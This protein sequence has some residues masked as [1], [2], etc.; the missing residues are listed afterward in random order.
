MNKLIRY[1]KTKQIIGLVFLV[2]CVESCKASDYW[3]KLI[4]E[5]E[6]PFYGL[7][8]DLTQEEALNCLREKG[9][10]AMSGEASLSEVKLIVPPDQ[11][12]EEMLNLDYALSFFHGEMYSAIKYNLD[13]EVLSDLL[14]TFESTGT[15]N[16]YGYAIEY[17]I[18]KNDFEY[19]LSMDENGIGTLSVLNLPLMNEVMMLWERIQ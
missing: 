7:S 15:R 2:F 18:E 8:L 17:I 16:D 6:L 12:I 4:N 19:S 13:S 10:P 5:G 14:Q 1:R 3:T 11:V 9:I